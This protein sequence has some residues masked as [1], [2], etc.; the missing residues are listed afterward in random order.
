MSSWMEVSHGVSPSDD[1]LTV[2]VRRGE[3]IEAVHQVI[4]VAA[5]DGRIIA[6]VGDPHH[7]CSL[8][9]S[10]KPVQ[11]EVVHSAVPDLDA[12]LLALA[13]ASHTAETYHLTG[14]DELLTLAGVDEGSLA[15]GPQPDRQPSRRY[16][17]CSGKHAAMLLACAVNGWPTKGYEHRNHQLQQDVE[18]R[19]AERAGVR[20]APDDFGVDGCGLPCHSMSLATM[21]GLFTRL[22]PVIAAALRQFPLMVGGPGIDDSD[23]MSAMPGWTAKRGAEGLLCAQTSSG[24][25]LAVKCLD[26]SSRP[27]R[28]A[29]AELCRRI[30]QPAPAAWAVGTVSNTL[31]APVGSICAHH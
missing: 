28:V 27:L 11:A 4:G 9:S 2:V 13:C 18:G 29:L 8:R 25:G 1:P 23:L 22:D 6:S 14:V 10:A 12:R 26:G 7:R 30:D 16:N 3:T 21:A 31:G 5:H 17:N 20:F 24:V 15:C 19:L